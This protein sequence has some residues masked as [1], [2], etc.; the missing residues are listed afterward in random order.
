[1][2]EPLLLLSGERASEEII[3]EESTIWKFSANRQILIKDAQVWQRSQMSERF[4]SDIFFNKMAVTSYQSNQFAKAKTIT[5]Y[6]GSDVRCFNRAYQR[7]GDKELA[8][9]SKK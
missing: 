5:K 2:L 1:M 8:W 3:I 9:T 4:A 7:F 6:L